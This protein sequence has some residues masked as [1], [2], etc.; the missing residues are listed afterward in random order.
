[1]QIETARLLLRPITTADLATTHAYA[2]D[3]DNTRYMMYLP[4]ESLEE[5]AQNLAEAEKQWRSPAPEMLE[6]AM[7]LAGQHI[8]S[9]MLIFEGPRDQ[10]ELGWV[11]HRDHWGHGYTTEAAQAVG[12]YAVRHMGVKRL[13]ACCDSENAASFRVMQKLGMR[14]VSALPGRYNRGM[15]GERIEITCER[16][17]NETE[18]CP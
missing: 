7:V 8:G 9:V 14:Q 1:M 12:E 6:F 13:F 11:I 16:W 4:T 15:E 5:T 2:S 17:Y 10:A 3:P 18:G